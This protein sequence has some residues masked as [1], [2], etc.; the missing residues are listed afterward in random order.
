[1]LTRNS[2]EVKLWSCEVF[3]RYRAIRNAKPKIVLVLSQDATTSPFRLFTSLENSFDAFALYA[4][5][6]LF[7]KILSLG[8]WKKDCALTEGETRILTL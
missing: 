3:S 2:E 7:Q 5:Q 1:M 6:L 8:N 4:Q